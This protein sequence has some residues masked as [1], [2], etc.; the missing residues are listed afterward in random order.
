MTLDYP[1]IYLIRDLRMCWIHKLFSFI[2]H[3]IEILFFH[4]VKDY[5]QYV[6]IYTH[7]FVIN[8]ILFIKNLITEN[9]I[10]VKWCSININNGL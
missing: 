1:V 8:V 4:I 5:I 6:V 10:F 7:T 9:I 3:F 2:V